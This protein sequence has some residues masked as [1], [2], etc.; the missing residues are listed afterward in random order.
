MTLNLTSDL[1]QGHLRI[2]MNVMKIQMAI[3]LLILSRFVWCF[4]HLI[5]LSQLYKYVNRQKV[6]SLSVLAENQ[7]M[8]F[9]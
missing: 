9:F 6:E 2:M 7:K 3:I 4:D 8:H 1:F 5:S